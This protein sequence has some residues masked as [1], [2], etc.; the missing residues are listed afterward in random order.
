MSEEQKDKVVD[1]GEYKNGRPMTAEDVMSFNDVEYSRCPGFKPGTVFVLRSV[2]AGD[3]IDWQEANEGE[4]KRTAGLRLIIK[5]VVDG[6][7]GVDPG[8]KGIPIFDDSALAMW[9]KRTHR[10]TENIV[11]HIIKLNGIGVKEDADAKKG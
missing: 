9:R 5:S 2:T 7:P 3:M 11:R 6:E 1:L 4:A 8:A 10:M